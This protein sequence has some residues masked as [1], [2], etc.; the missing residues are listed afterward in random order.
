MSC[1][2]DY[3]DQLFLTT[4]QVY[5]EEAA[6]KLIRPGNIH[7]EKLKKIETKS[8]ELPNNTNG[9]AYWISST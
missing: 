5:E 3:T 8:M 2:Q 9:F 6:A 7:E 1:D 4:S